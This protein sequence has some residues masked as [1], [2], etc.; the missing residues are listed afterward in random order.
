MH[1]G[2]ALGEPRS[3]VELVYPEKIF[4]C[5]S[6]KGAGMNKELRKA[7]KK[8]CGRFP[9]QEWI[10]KKDIAHYSKKNCGTANVIT[11]VTK[12]ALTRHQSL[13]FPANWRGSRK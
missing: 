9:G 11:Y 13:G 12:K 7:Y 5:T 4:C 3:C 2:G 1:S 6:C 10:I 8:L